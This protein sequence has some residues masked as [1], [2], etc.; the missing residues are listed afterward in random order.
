MSLVGYNTNASTTKVSSISVDVSGIVIQPND[1]AIILVQGGGG[2]SNTYTFPAESTAPINGLANQDVTGDSTQGIANFFMAGTETSVTVSSSVTD[3]LTAGVV[4][5]RGRSLSNPF[6]ATNNTPTNYTG[7][8]PLSYSLQGITAGA[9]DDV[10]IFIANKFY[11]GTNAMSYASPGGAFGTGHIAYGAVQYSPCLCFCVAQNVSA[12][13][14]GTAGGTLTVPGGR[15][16][17]GFAAMV[18][19]MPPMQSSSALPCGAK[20]T[21]VTNEIIQI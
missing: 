12:G 5:F 4:V 8:S 15:T 18:L 10:L 6:T 16:D 14:I 3:Y 19:S 2:V 17:L 9:N 11:D 13:S 1:H 21:F 20:Q 7:T